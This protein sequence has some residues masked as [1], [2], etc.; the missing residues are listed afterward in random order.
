M[1]L[2]A[3]TSSVN[4]YICKNRENPWNIYKRLF[5]ELQGPFKWDLTYKVHYPHYMTLQTKL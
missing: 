5:S 4:H 3:K 2:I 1:L